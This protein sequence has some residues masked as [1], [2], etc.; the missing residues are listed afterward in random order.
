MPE[1]ETA[2]LRLSP[3]NLEDLDQLTAILSNPEVMKYSPR[4]LLPK[5]QE[6]QLTQGILEFFINHWKQHGFGV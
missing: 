1:I 3:Y 5:G 6:K 4:G 2:R